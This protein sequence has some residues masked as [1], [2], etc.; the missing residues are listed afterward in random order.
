MI[1]IVRP[2]E[3]LPLSTANL[4]DRQ[5]GADSGIAAMK[6]A[7]GRRSMAMPAPVAIRESMNIPGNSH[8]AGCFIRPIH[9]VEESEPV[10]VMPMPGGVR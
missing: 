10:M 3:V 9:S 2:L 7:T 6:A 4:K 5:N 8:Q 1:S